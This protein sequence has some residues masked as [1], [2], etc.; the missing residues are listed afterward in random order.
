MVTLAS[1][2]SVSGIMASSPWSITQ[3]D[4]SG[5]V[6]FDTSIYAPDES[7]VFISYRESFAAWNGHLKFAKS[8]DGGQTWNTKTVDPEWDVGLHTSIYAPDSNTIF[9]SYQARSY[10]VGTFDLRFAKSTDG[11]ETWMTQTVDSIGDVGYTTAISAMDINTILISYYDQTNSAL[12]FAKSVDG[13]QTWKIS[14]IDSPGDVGYHTSIARVGDSV[15]IGYIDF[16]AFPNFA[17]K[18]VK[19][20]DRGDSW[21]APKVV[22]SGSNFGYTSIYPVDA[23]LIYVSYYD[24]TN[25]VLKLAKS[26]NGGD[27]SF[28]GL[29]PAD[30]GNVFGHPTIRKMS[31]SSILIGYHD[32]TDMKLKLAKSTD[33]GQSWTRFVVDDGTDTGRYASMHVV[34]DKIYMS[35]RDAISQTLKFAKASNGLLTV[36]TTTTLT[37]PSTTTTIP[38]D[39]TPP[40]TA[41]QNTIDGNNI[42]VPNS[43]STSSATMWITFTGTDNVNVAGFECRLDSSAW[44]SCTSPLTFSAMSAGTHLFEV[45]AVDKAGNRDPTPAGFT[46]TVTSPTS[47]T[48]TAVSTT[49]TTLNASATTTT[50]LPPTTTLQ[51]VTTTLTLPLQTT[52]TA[53]TTTTTL[54]KVEVSPE[55]REKTAEN[56]I[57]ASARMPSL[58][59]KEEALIEIKN[60]EIAVRKTAIQVKEAVKDIEVTIRQLPEKPAEVAIIE[61][62]VYRYLEIDSTQN[63]KIRSARVEFGVDEDWI[64]KNAGGDEGQIRLNRYKE[65]KWEELPTKRIGKEGG[66]VRYEAETQGFSVFV[67]SIAIPVT[68]TA[69]PQEIIP[70][71]TPQASPATYLLYLIP[72]L[73]FAGLLSY[74]LRLIGKK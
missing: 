58:T 43:G 62:P 61:S 4:D 60:E 13:G 64:A 39:T 36:T 51:N 37:S 32:E 21:N 15:F 57:E 29:T 41:I 70:V 42:Y 3:A 48:I 69:P 68:A 73:L 52:T 2:A 28:T 18:F 9:I 24:Y 23:S 11:G 25:K 22:E 63:E 20:T 59:V 31:D 50:T 33:G 72:L 1:L 7:T 74:T 46:W 66:K 12:K 10:S 8:V 19:S 53:A 5:N 34:G 6:G 27:T 49:T 54:Q 26:S 30:S 55:E 14:A 40:D 71:T 47:T 17:V 67:I 65:G 16:S 35:Y 44:A 45:K 56:I 38:S